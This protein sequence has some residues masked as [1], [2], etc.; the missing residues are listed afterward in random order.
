MET[1]PP[2]SS[3][4]GTFWML[5]PVVLLG[6]S[7]IGVGSIASIAAHDPGFALE[8]NYYERAVH[9]DRQAAEWAEDERLGYRLA[10]AVAPVPAGAE[11]A[12]RVADHAGA[13]LHGASVR[14][15]AFAVARSAERR[16]L[17]LVE[18]ADG[19]YRAALAGTRPGLWEFRCVVTA[20]SDRYTEVV[21]ADVTRS[22]SP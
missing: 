17:E 13:P 4:H 14:V 22:A 9:W 2:A 16:T 1:V 20:G 21:R 18:G 6:A 11:L 5:V 15:E 19:S 8:K 7:V 12:V 10:L 3:G